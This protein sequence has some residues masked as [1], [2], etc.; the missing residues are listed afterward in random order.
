[1]K[2]KKTTIQELKNTF[3]EFVKARNWEQFHS[4]K[5]LSMCI[6]TEAAELMEH[7]LWA[8]GRN[9]S[10]KAMED[11]RAEI[12]KEVA[13]IAFGLLQFCTMNN[14]DLTTAIETKL[15]E[16]NVRYAVDK[17][18]GRSGKISQ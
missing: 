8:E 2:D 16:L 4:A 14:I 17:V 15:Q 13:D 1:M 18:Y 9:E 11:N 6:A 10:E 12:E 3:N 7:F 5:N